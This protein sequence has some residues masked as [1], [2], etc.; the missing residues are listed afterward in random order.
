MAIAIYQIERKR[1][2]NDIPINNSSLS[3]VTVY[4]IESNRIE[5]NQNMYQLIESI[6]FHIN[7]ITMI[8]KKGLY[9]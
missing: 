6:K 5:P 7:D 1:D 8:S 4:Q 3:S 9:I 2:I